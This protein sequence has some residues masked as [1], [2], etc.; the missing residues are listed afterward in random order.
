MPLTCEVERLGSIIKRFGIV[1][2][3]CFACRYIPQRCGIQIFIPR[4]FLKFEYMEHAPQAFYKIAPVSKN[5][6]NVRLHFNNP[7]CILQLRIDLLCR[8]ELIK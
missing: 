8:F 4:M 6:S 2:K 5:C 7:I 1:R 3:V